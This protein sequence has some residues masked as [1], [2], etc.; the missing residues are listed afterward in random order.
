MSWHTAL[1]RVGVLDNQSR[2]PSARSAVTTY[3]SRSALI[4]IDAVAFRVTI[5]AGGRSICV[6]A[7]RIERVSARDPLGRIE[8]LIIVLTEPAEL[9]VVP[10]VGRTER[11]HLRTLGSV[12]QATATEARLAAALDRRMHQGMDSA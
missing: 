2:G 3:A 6:N 10:A 5:S 7:S 8:G 1:S 9:I 12:M 4:T 11:R